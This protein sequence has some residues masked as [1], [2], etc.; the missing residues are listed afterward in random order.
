MKKLT[1]VTLLSIITATPF[2]NIAQADKAT[3]IKQHLGDVKSCLSSSGVQCNLTKFEGSAFSL[4][5]YGNIPSN[6]LNQCISTY[7]KKRINSPESPAILFITANSANSSKR[8][9]QTN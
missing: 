5:G 1:V 3:S 7:D 8:I 6:S 9:I 2:H 4:T